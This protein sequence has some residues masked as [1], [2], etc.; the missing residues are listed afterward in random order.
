VPTIGV[1]C[2]VILNGKGYFVQPGTYKMTR[3]RVSIMTPMRRLPVGADPKQWRD[4]VPIRWTD[5]GPRQRIW[6]MKIQCYGSLLRYDGTPTGITGYD[7]RD[8]LQIAYQHTAQILPFT[9]PA[10]VCRGV[11]FT[12]FIE[13][14]ADLRA[15]ATALNFL[16]TIELTEM[17]YPGGPP[18]QPF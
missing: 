12:H 5:R 18:I 14:I 4:G 6:T 8:S 7:Y 13:E 3:P 1:D 16:V 15:Q 2:Q 11:A 17:D 10:G 9:D